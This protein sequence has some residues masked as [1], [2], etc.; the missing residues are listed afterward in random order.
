MLKSEQQL[1]ISLPLH[2]YVSIPTRELPP[3]LTGML[4]P[5]HMGM[6]SCPVALSFTEA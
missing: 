1:R 6:L 5:P 2:F 4:S 3:K